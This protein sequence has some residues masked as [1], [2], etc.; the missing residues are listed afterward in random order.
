MPRKDVTYKEAV[1]QDGREFLQLSGQ[2]AGSFSEDRPLG[3]DPVARRAIG[4]AMEWP[5]LVS[6]EKAAG[7]LPQS[8]CGVSH[9]EFYGGAAGAGF[10]HHHLPVDAVLQGA[11]MGDDAHQPVALGQPRQHP[12]GLFQ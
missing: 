6:E 8:T 12:H 2:R 4:R 9:N 5:E 1:K 7:T 3:W 11:H 10:A